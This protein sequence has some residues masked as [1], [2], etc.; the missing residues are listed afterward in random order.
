MTYNHDYNLSGVSMDSLRHRLS[1]LSIEG[2]EYEDEGREIQ[3][4]IGSRDMVVRITKQDI[5]GCPDDTHCDM[6]DPRSFDSVKVLYD[7]DHAKK[8]EYPGAREVQAHIRR[9]NKEN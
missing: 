8:F 4:E 3:D 9:S 1:Q 7:I 2:L 6:C 5:C